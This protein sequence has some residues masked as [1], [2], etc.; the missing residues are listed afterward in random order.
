MAQVL[1]LQRRDGT[2]E[3]AHIGSP[4]LAVVFE[5]AHKHEPVSAADNGW[6]AYY[7]IHGEAPPDRAAL[8][9]WLKQ[10]VGTE[11]AEFT[12]DPTEATANGTAGPDSSSPT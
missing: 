3:V 4:Y 2:T 11:V 10:F 6:M 12:P 7:D 1:V 8:L 5:D 9:E